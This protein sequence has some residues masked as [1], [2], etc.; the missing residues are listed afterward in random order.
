MVCR[1]GNL[2]ERD[3]Q[4]LS[5]KSLQTKPGVQRFGGMSNVECGMLEGFKHNHISF[6]IP[7]SPFLEN[8]IGPQLY[9]YL[10]SFALHLTP[11]RAM[12]EAQPQR[13]RGT[14]GNETMKK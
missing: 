3:K 9:F 4:E 10:I 6:L 13:K 7:R 8:P 1:T 5:K 11:N 14:F 12:K 2:G